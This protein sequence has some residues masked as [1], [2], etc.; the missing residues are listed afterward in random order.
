MRNARIALVSLFL[1]TFATQAS[2]AEERKD[3]KKSQTPRAAA[4]KTKPRVKAESK[5]KTEARDTEKRPPDPL[6]KGAGKVRSKENPKDRMS[7]DDFE[8][9]EQMK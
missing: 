2:A 8:K 3:P 6:E 4:T 1:L 9:R 5:A 7:P